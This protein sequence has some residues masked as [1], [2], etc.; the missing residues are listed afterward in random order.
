M[1]NPTSKKVSL[2]FKVVT[3]ICIISLINSFFIKIPVGFVNEEPSPIKTLSI[4]VIAFAADRLYIP[5]KIQRLI[6]LNMIVPFFLIIIGGISV[7]EMGRFSND[8]INVNSRGVLYQ[9]AFACSF[10]FLLAHEGNKY[11]NIIAL[12]TSLV[13]IIKS[14]SRLDF[15]FIVLAIVFNFALLKNSIVKK[16]FIQRIVI[17]IIMVGGSAFILKN[18]MEAQK[19]R[20]GSFSFETVFSDNNNELSKLERVDYIMTGFE[21]SKYYPF[22]VGERNIVDAIITYGGTYV[23]DTYNVHSALAQS[24]FIAGWLGALIWFIFVFKMSKLALR[25]FRKWY[26]M[27]VYILLCTFTQPLI[28]SKLFWIVVIFFEKEV[29]HIGNKQYFEQKQTSLTD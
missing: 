1:I 19:H 25:D 16:T 20:F 18:M 21:V 24:L 17:I 10:Y 7:N 3:V 15:I 23:K 12:F 14:G 22:G 28:F 6:I 8:L 27:L 2:G 9:M 4:F 26:F 5:G 13:L 11:L 29:L